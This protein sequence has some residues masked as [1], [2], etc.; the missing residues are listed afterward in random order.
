MIKIACIDFLIWVGQ[1]KKLSAYAE[2]VNG[3]ARVVG[4]PRYKITNGYIKEAMEL[5]CCRRIRQL[6]SWAVPG[7]SRVFLVHRGP[8]KEPDKG[9]IFGYYVLKRIE[10]IAQQKGPDPLEQ[11]RDKSPW[12]DKYREEFKKGV[13]SCRGSD[14][15]KACIMDKYPERLKDNLLRDV[16]RERIKFSGRPSKKYKDP[17]D[18]LID[19]ILKEFMKKCWEELMERMDNDDYAIVTREQALMAAGLGCSKREVPGAAYLVNALFGET[20][21]AFHEKL[22]RWLEQEGPHMY[23]GVSR[24]KLIEK[25]EE[26]ESK[27]IYPEEGIELFREAKREVHELRKLEVGELVLLDKPY[28]SFQ[29]YPSAAFRG[30]FRIDG[31]KLLDRINKGGKRVTPK[32]PYCTGEEIEPDKPMTK[33][34]LVDFLKE[35]LHLQKT[36][37]NKFFDELSS[38]AIDELKSKKYIVLPGLGRLV[39]SERKARHEINPKTGEKISIPAKRVLKFR[40]TKEIEDKINLQKSG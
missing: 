26:T 23:P 31:D 25:L 24:E 10:F 35:E 5:G 29:R 22:Y 15:E 40:P 6:P 21:D 33:A 11:Y 28:P 17:F 1:P 39:V 19:E 4:P 38:L 16:C 30:Y 13:E 37:V 8:H 36:M 9:S 12:S 7:K 20:T 3:E 18:E 34:Q 14:D 32:I 2:K 27:I